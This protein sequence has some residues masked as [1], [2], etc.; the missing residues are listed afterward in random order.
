MRLSHLSPPALLLAAAALVGC[1]SVGQ[2]TGNEY[3]K[4][5]S[6]L[7]WVVMPD[8]APPSSENVSVWLRYK[9]A[10]GTGL[11][12]RAQVEQ[13][14]QSQGY[15]LIDS[16]SDADYQLVATLRHF[17]KA[18]RFDGGEGAMNTVESA[19]PIAGTVAGAVVGYQL[20][21][22]GTGAVAGGIVGGASGL[23]AS[24]A[25]DNASKVSEWDLVLDLQ[26]NE[27]IEG[28]FTEQVEG[29]SKAEAS[30]QG[31]VR[32]GG[33]MEAGG[34]SSSQSR[35]AEL[36]RERTHFSNTGRLVAV[37]YQMTMSREEALQEL[38]P[39]LPSAVASALP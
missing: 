14:V 6:K 18:A 8:L 3:A 16:P 32:G 7:E 30:T 11:D 20:A 39:R 35:S 22:S 2:F 33:R 4:P 36:E 34:N 29:A 9:D 26:V 37:A 17:D 13:A 10:S 27:R 38:L 21:E 15:K 19:A 24:A 1:R 5:Q 23:L 31:A 25:M 28:G 12:L